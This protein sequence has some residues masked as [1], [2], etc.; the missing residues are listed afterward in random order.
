MR[1]VIIICL[2]LQVTIAWSQNK[3]RL[4]AS[5]HGFRKI[6]IV[7]EN[8]N[9]EWQYNLKEGQCN[10]LSMLADSTILFSYVSGA[11]LINLDKELLWDFKGAPDTEIQSI[12]PLK[13]GDFLIMQ[14][15]TPAKLMEVDRAGKIKKQLIIP[16]R[17]KHPHA[18]FRNIRKTNKGTYLIG[19]H[20]EDKVCEFNRKGKLIK[21]FRL[22]KGSNAYSSV[23]LRNGNTL[24]ACGDAHMLIELNKKGEIVWS[25]TENELPG[26]PLRFVAGV[27]R[28]KNG[29][30][31]ICN[32]GG[33]GHKE[34]QAQIIEVTPDK[35]VV[36]ELNDWINLGTLCTVQVLDE[37]GIMEKGELYR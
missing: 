27:Q 31:V 36:Y 26:H 29:N 8:K 19:Y 3:H 30:T 7:D 15:G 13:N 4:I 21:T 6:V 11:C 14:N 34:Q 9:I 33:H 35:K 23:R 18:Q 24:V 25:I 5:G 1:N 22:P 37:P 10:D 2:M 16:T 20:R 17:M 28:L 12:S 32:W